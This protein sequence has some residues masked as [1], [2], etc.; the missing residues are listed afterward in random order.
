MTLLSA[1]C[2]KTTAPDLSPVRFGTK[3]VSIAQLKAL[4]TGQTVKI[5]DGTD[6][7]QIVGV[8]ISDK[9]GKNIDPNTIVLQSEGTD[10]AG[11]VINFD[12]IAP[13]TLGDRLSINV[14]GQ[15]LVNQQGEILVSKVPLSQVQYMGKGYIKM[16]STTAND[17]VKN[18]DK[19]NG[20]L[21][22][23]YDG[24]FINGNGKYDGTLTFKETDSTQVIKSTILS[25]AEF[26]HTAYPEGINTITGIFRTNGKDHFVQ[27]RTAADVTSST[28]T[29]IVTDNMIGLGIT[30]YGRYYWE[31]PYLY[32]GGKFETTDFR[33]TTNG[34]T[35]YTQPYSA[36][37]G[38]LSPGRSYLH[39]LN[40]A[41]PEYYSSR[42]QCNIENQ[43]SLQ[44]LKELRVS[45]IGSAVTGVLGS[46]EAD[47]ITVRPFN[48][49]VDSFR[50][51][52]EFTNNG[53]LVNLGP[54]ASQYSIAY[55]QTGK[56]YTAVF[57]IPTRHEMMKYAPID[58]PNYAVSVSNW[59]AAPGFNITNFSTR[60]DTDPNS[61]YE[62]YAPVVI[63]KIEYA[64]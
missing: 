54:A 32:D 55:K 62:G 1:A 39:L 13:F 48:P 44:G 10:T 19:W 2:N 11:I 29:R 36:D 7:K 28:I 57:R 25:G 49:A 5:P 61:W 8:V 37:A 64:F 45:F 14:S 24:A 63:T 47:T 18:A 33:Y 46:S 26:E 58:D 38:I 12:S 6:G 16:Y 51:Y 50:L 60:T 40:Y 30:R 27:I 17:L 3:V 52:L 22:T 53:Y 59:L 21:V 9:T 42:S 41:P 34:Q 20:T 23:L 4:S 43:G 35:A 15:Q 56:I 31:Q